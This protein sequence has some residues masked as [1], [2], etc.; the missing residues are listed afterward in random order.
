MKLLNHHDKSLSISVR[1]YLLMNEG[2]ADYAW[3]W[4]SL[5]E[6]YTLRPEDKKKLLNTAVLLTLC[7]RRGERI[8]DFEDQCLE[9]MDDAR[10]DDP[11]G[12]MR[13][14][15]RWSVDVGFDSHSINLP[16][17]IKAEPASEDRLEYYLR[18]PPLELPIANPNPIPPPVKQEAF[19][20]LPT[21]AQDSGF[22]KTGKSIRLAWDAISN[23][24]N[25]LLLIWVA[26]IAMVGV[27]F[28]VF[29]VN[30][31]PFEP[32]GVSIP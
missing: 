13:V 20:D 3:T 8:E 22:Y 23:H 1:T 16:G 30:R 10:C 7:L 21:P 6:E 11:S 9:A 15:R 29:I 25:R 5:Y 14:L 32:S 17:P 24:I 26:V 12:L 27:V 2:K 28:I 4:T 18:Q 19:R 31:H